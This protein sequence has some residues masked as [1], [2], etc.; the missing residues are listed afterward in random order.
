[1]NEQRK[2]TGRGLSVAELEKQTCGKKLYIWGAGRVGKSVLSALERNGFKTEAFL[3]KNP[4]Y[5]DIVYNGIKTISPESLFEKKLNEDAFLIFSSWM[6]HVNKDMAATLKSLE[7]KYDARDT[8][9]IPRTAIQPF[10]PSV[11][12]AGFCNLRCIACPVGDASRPRDKGGLMNTETFK[13]V[14]DKLLGEIPFLMELCL[15][16]WGDPLLKPML[17]EMIKICNDAGVTPFISTNLNHGKYLEEIIK[18]NPPELMIAVSGFGPEHY[19]VTHFGGKWD[20]FYANLLKLR[21]YIDKYHA[22]TIPLVYFHANKTNLAEYKPMYELCKKLSFRLRVQPSLVLHDIVKDYAEKKELSE[23]AK[24]AV[25]IQFFDMD[26]ILRAAKTQHKNKCVFTSALPNIGWDLSLYPCCNYMRK[27]DVNYLEM[28]FEDVVALSND[29]P[30]C[31]ECI[32]L[33]VHRAVP[34]A[35]FEDTIR[36][37]ILAMHGLPDRL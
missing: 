26:E 36:E 22:D 24:K 17:P 16:L 2:I 14:L 35:S 21:E 8:A 23:S 13:K 31:G 10:H 7:A 1:V 32:N 6:T 27:K 12:I 19:E 11:D 18:A 28:S 34:P 5:K 3:D 4:F 29:S 15:Y 25:D 33:S 37:Q 30:F 9:F 20:L